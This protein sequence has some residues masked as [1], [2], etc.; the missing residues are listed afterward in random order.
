MNTLINTCASMMGQKLGSDKC[1]K[2]HT[3]KNQNTYICGKGKVDAWV[4]E[5]GKTEEGEETF[6][7]KKKTLL[8]YKSKLLRTKSI[9]A[10]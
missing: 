10:K 3:G 4:D 5:L 1:V 7:D 8:K 6:N 2:M 9:L